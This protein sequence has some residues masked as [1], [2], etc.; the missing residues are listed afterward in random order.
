MLQFCRVGLSLGILI[1]TILFYEFYE[2]KT[3]AYA[4]YTLIA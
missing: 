3:I 1:Y 4:M 2:N